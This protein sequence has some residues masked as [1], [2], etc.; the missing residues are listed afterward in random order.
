MII[1]HS[2]SFIPIWKSFT[3]YKRIV[4]RKSFMA[5]DFG[6][7]SGIMIEIKSNVANNLYQC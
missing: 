5:I 3:F 1:H 4:S 7:L 6:G 2:V